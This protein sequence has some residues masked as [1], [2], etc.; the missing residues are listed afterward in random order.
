MSTVYEGVCGYC[1]DVLNDKVPRE[2]LFDMEELPVNK[3]EDACWVECGVRT[4]RAQYV[5]E[6]SEALN[7][8]FG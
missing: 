4:C 7:V 1:E 2:S 3:P 8:S 6:D 5:V